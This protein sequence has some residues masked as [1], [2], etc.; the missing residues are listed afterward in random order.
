MKKWLAVPLMLLILAAA[1]EG[2]ILYAGWR[3]AGLAEQEA[4]L[5]RDAEAS[6]TYELAARQLPW[7]A[8][9]WE[10]AGLAAFRGQEPG[11]AIRLLQIAEK[12]APLSVDGSVA[13]GSALWTEGE[14]STA[15][16]AWQA[17]M[18]THPGDPALLDRLIAAYD[19]QRAYA[20]EQ[21]ALISRL[22]AGQDPSA[23]YRLGLLLMVSDPSRADAEL[24]K[25]ASLDSRFE[26]AVTTL[27]AALQAA[28]HEPETTGRLVVIGRGLGLVEEWGPALEAFDQ[29]IHADRQNADAWAW[30]GEAQ[31]HLGQDGRQALDEAVRLDPRDAVI[32][33]LRALYF[34]R[35]G[36]HAAAVA[37]QLQAAQLQPQNPELQLALGEAYAAAGDLV[38]ALTAYQQATN[39]APQDSS[40][41]TQLAAFCANNGV[42]VDTVGLPAALKAASLAPH[43]AQALDILGWSYAQTG[44]PQ[45]AKEKLLQAIQAQPDL[46]MAH[47]HLA[48]V[49]L[50]MGDYVSARGEFNEATGLD[51]NGAAGQLAAQL[52]RQYFP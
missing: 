28:A 49:Y 38:A 32:H 21:T 22:A 20:E 25:A 17:G 47:L 42:Q 2:P 41:W 5:G 3:N 35:Q 16:A 11:E 45:T 52:L 24:Q 39:L 23:S 31:Q 10:Q 6:Q 18:R 9:L 44:L 46:A 30:F 27:R 4:G 50:R 14:A 8:E 48:E 15:I 37:E 40:T 51:P 12:R 43:D 7:R 34:A 26:P 33:A 13:L 19:Q 1:V 36:D 29:A